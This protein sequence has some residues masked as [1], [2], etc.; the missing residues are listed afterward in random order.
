MAEE[1]I[2]S[3]PNQQQ[4][5]LVV[6]EREMRIAFANGYR[7]YTTGEEVV[8]DF[9]FNML[10]PNP[11]AGQAQML[12]KA[13]DRVILSY[14]TVKRLSISLAQLVKRYED[15]FGSIAIQPGGQP[16]KR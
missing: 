2:S 4:V 7:I 1:I 12:F 13:G 3:D 6:D 14:P 5:Q 15:Q 9:G 11:Q 10:N 8:V 16:G